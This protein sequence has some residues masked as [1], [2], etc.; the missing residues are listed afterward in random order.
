MKSA[1][2]LGKD[3]KPDIEYRAQV[4]IHTANKNQ[5]NHQ[6]IFLHRF[7]NYTPFEYTLPQRFFPFSDSSL[8][9]ARLKNRTG[10]P[11]IFLDSSSHGQIDI[12]IR[13]CGV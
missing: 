1:N 11:K 4:E 8:L 5:P 12:D 6:E 10:R 9:Q 7:W 13:G 2:A 3:S